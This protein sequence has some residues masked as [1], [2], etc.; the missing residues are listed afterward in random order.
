MQREKGKILFLW[1]IVS[2]YLA[3]F[4]KKLTNG[5]KYSKYL[6]RETEKPR[7]NKTFFLYS[8][9]FWWGKSLSHF[10]KYLVL[11]FVSLILA[12]GED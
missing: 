6:L 9:F 8:Q 2:R 3:S 1:H 12:N 5:V 11:N 10:N 4:K 7:Q